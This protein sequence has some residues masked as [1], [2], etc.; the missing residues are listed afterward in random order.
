MHGCP[1]R[2][3][4]IGWDRT[5]PLFDFDL[6]LSTLS[7]TCLFSS[8]CFL[9]LTSVREAWWSFFFSMA[10]KFRDMYEVV[11]PHTENFI[12]SYMYL[13]APR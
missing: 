12:D 3:R 2:V 1:T 5:K 13:G 9:L 4:S 6:Y 7:L 11:D 8:L 10:G